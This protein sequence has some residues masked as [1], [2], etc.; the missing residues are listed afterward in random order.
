MPNRSLTRAKNLTARLS[1]TRKE[2]LT[3]K[4]GVTRTRNLPTAATGTIMKEGKPEKNLA[5]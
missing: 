2:R 4:T 3:I 5:D 1:L